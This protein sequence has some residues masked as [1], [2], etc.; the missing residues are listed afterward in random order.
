MTQLTQLRIEILGGSLRHLDVEA[1]DEGLTAE[2]LR[3]AV[4]GELG[5][6]W[7][8]CAVIV[9]GKNASLLGGRR[10]KTGHVVALP[11]LQARRAARLRVEILGGPRKH[12]EIDIGD[13]GLTVEELRDAVQREIGTT[14]YNCAVIVNGQSASFLKDQ[15]I[16]K[17]HVV[18]VLRQMAGGTHG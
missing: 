5:E 9:N 15:R 4:Q 10:I 2:E 17:G 13:Q 16:K 18:A 11:S 3:K 7:Q 6:D 12:V 14:W 8:D 1:G